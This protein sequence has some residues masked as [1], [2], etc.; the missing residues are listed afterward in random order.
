MASLFEAQ[1]ATCNGT[2]DATNLGCG[3]TLA[4][5]I[6]EEN[7]TDTVYFAEDWDDTAGQLRLK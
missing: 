7:T 6:N 2:G 4:P 5:S 3:F 1:Y